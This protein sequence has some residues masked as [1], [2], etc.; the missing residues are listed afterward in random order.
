M[1]SPPTGPG[2]LETVAG[3]STVGWLPLSSPSVVLPMTDTELSGTMDDWYN[4][5][6]STN[7][8]W[9]NLSPLPPGLASNQTTLEVVLLGMTQIS[10]FCMDPSEIESN[11]K[12]QHLVTSVQVLCKQVPY[13]GKVW[14]GETL[15]NWVC[16]NLWWINR[17]ANRLFIVSTN[18]DDFSLANHRQFAKFTKLSRYTVYR[19][20]GK[21]GE[22]TLFEHLV[23]ESLAINRSANRLSIVSTKLNGFSLTNHGRFTKFAKLSPT[24]LSPAKLSSYTVYLLQTPV[25]QWNG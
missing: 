12:P 24:K 1:R 2:R 18:L 14:R 7:F 16:S 22:L 17:S 6:W 8:G 25:P 20:A 23:K 9:R 10:L 5:W 13:S 4:T 11:W 19:I 3:N 15:V 21:F